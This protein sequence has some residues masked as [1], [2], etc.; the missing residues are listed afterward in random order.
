VIEP[1]FKARA[2][3]GDPLFKTDVFKVMDRYCTWNPLLFEGYTDVDRQTELN[4]DD[5]SLT[6]YVNTISV[7]E[8]PFFKAPVE[9]F[10]CLSDLTAKT[11]PYDYV[12][13]V[14]YPGCAVAGNC[15]DNIWSQDCANPSCFGVPLYRQYRTGDESKTEAHQVKMMGQSI[16]QRSTLSVNGGKYYVDTTVGQGTQQAS[17]SAHF[18][19]FQG[20]QTY[21]LF[22]LFGKSTTKQTYQIY[23]GD[24]FNKDDPAQLSARRA[25]VDSLPIK[26]PNLLWPSGWTRKYGTADGLPSGI[27][28]VTI[29]L[30]AFKPVFDGSGEDLCRPKRFCKWDSRQTKNKCQCAL[31]RGD[32]FYDECKANDSEICSWSVKD[33]ACPDGGCYGIAVTLPGGFDNNNLAS[34][35]PP[36]ACFPTSQTPWNVNF[37]PAP[38]DLAGACHQG[39]PP[40]IPG[41]RE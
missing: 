38:V 41:C 24:G 34:Q 22:L 19:V 1:F 10:E 12:T 11:S 7:N 5:G 26:F 25:V 9:A 20:G 39:D 15:V 30:A 16:Y 13:T 32:Y 28:E 4:D 36:T 21:Y 8:D 40:P 33:F 23:V 29:D 3:E 2:S 17:R 31:S 14:V 37:T 35:R 6:G 27:L 18:S